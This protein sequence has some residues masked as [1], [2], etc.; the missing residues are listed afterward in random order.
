MFEQRGGLAHRQRV[1]PASSAGI[2]SG[3]AWLDALLDASVVASFDRTGWERHRRGFDPSDLSVD[4][5]G[6][7]VVITGANSGI[8]FATARALVAR[9]ATAWC[10][11]RDRARGEAAVASLREVGRAELLLLDVSDLDSVRAAPAGLPARLHALVHNAGMMEHA[12][13]RSRQGLDTTFATH[14]AGPHLL[15]GLLADRLEGGRIVWVSSGGMYTRKLDVDA[16]VEPPAP[17]DG[18][19]AYARCKRAQVVLARL[20]AERLGPRGVTV[21]AMHPGWVDTPAVRTALPR[22]WRAMQGRLRDT[23]AGADTVVWLVA[24]AR[25]SS[26]AG[27]PNGAFWFDRAPR[28]PWLVPGTR[29]RDPAALWRRLEELTG[30]PTR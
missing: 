2:R 1:D 3:M 21:S 10:A 20:W 14:V 16:T 22:F 12:Q 30:R 13:T 7:D 29:E 15:T 11:C 5:T 18:V 9:G 6:R 23:E 17:F 25:A 28:S 8:G 24:A 4:L 27:A 26:S 19:D